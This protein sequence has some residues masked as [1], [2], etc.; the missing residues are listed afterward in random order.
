MEAFLEANKAS[1]DR[2]AVQLY[3]YAIQSY[4]WI[5]A[6][7]PEHFHS[8]GYDADLVRA[9]AARLHREGHHDAVRLV[10][11]DTF[12]ELFCN[13]TVVP[14][15][16]A[17]RERRAR[18]RKSGKASVSS[19]FPDWAALETSVAPETRWAKRDTVLDISG[20]DLALFRES[21]GVKR[22]VER[23]R[24]ES[25]RSTLADY[26]W[27]FDSEWGAASFLC[28]RY[29]ML[30]DGLP[31]VDLAR[32]LAVGSDS[33]LHGGVGR[34]P[35]GDTHVVANLLMRE[36]NV[37][38]KLALGVVVPHALAASRPSL[39]TDAFRALRFAADAHGSV[40]QQHLEQ[41]AVTATV[42]PSLWSRL[43][44]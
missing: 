37:V 11:D 10:A 32:S 29:A 23:W 24:K 13:Q 17:Y 42:A 2:V 30:S 19:L 44:R 39:V 35:T 18:T 1:S 8:A 4:R 5:E 16:S 15:L 14:T 40:V 28:H 27:V 3:T 43:W 31:R 21:G 9:Y 25:E 26:R 20:D 22:A 36:Q 6:F 34:L 41:H 12:P 38:V 33:V 7:A